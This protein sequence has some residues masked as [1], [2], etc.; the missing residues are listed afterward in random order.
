MSIQGNFNNGLRDVALAYGARQ[1]KE[2]NETLKQKGFTDYDDLQRSI[3]QLKIQI[4]QAKD[5]G[6]AFG[7]QKA[8]LEEYENNDS[9]PHKKITQFQLDLN[10]K[11]DELRDYIKTINPLEVTPI[12]A[13]V[14]L[15]KIKKKSEE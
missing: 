5:E 7:E 9:K 3:G 8:L 4:A 15:D 14:I 6:K 12:E 13:L 2:I 10:T 11:N 1:L